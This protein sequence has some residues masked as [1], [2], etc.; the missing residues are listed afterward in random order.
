MV[1]AIKMRLVRL[2]LLA[3]LL[4][5]PMVRRGI[6][7][8]HAIL[9]AIG[10]PLYTLFDADQ[11]CGDRASAKG[12]HQKQID[13]LLAKNAKENRILLKYFGLAEED[14]PG[15]VVGEHVAIFDDKSRNISHTALA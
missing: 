14:F 4:C 8:V 5:L 12:Q 11:G 2:R 10:I 1:S 7:L 13:N 6:P 3:S 9:S 15:A